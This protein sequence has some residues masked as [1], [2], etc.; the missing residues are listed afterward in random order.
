MCQPRI[1]GPVT[2]EV[3]ATP[4]PRKGR[5]WIVLALAVALFALGYAIVEIATKPPGRGVVRINAIDNAQEIFGGVPQE[6][7][8]LGSSDAPVTI[9]V[10]A[11]MQCGSCREDFLSTIPALTT[12]YA[13]QGD[14]K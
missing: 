7:D 2:S 5:I 4:M 14:V 6:G 1:M 10:F 9:Q 11:D 8:R 12:N 3:A 13:R